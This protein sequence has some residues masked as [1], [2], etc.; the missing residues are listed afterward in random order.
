MTEEKIKQNKKALYKIFI[1]RFGRLMMFMVILL[2]FHAISILNI[3]PIT[4]LELL[5]IALLNLQFSLYM[6]LYD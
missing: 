1:E 2:I 3:E 5:L 6:W 4:K